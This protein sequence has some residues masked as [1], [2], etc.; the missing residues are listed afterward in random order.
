MQFNAT[1]L[2]LK[3]SIQILGQNTSIRAFYAGNLAP[4]MTNL[5]QNSLLN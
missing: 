4:I 2:L 1:F 5:H 3:Y